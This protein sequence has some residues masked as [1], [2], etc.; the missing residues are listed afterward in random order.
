MRLDEFEYDRKVKTYLEHKQYASPYY[1]PVKAHE[2]YEQHKQLKGNKRSTSTASLNEKGKKAALYVKKQIDEEHKS[3]TEAHNQEISKQ[4]EEAKSNTK[5]KIDA[6]TKE[7]KDKAEAM[8]VRLKKMNPAQRKQAQIHMKAEIEKLKK[9]NEE[10][11]KALMEEYGEV[12]KGISE[13]AKAKRGEINDKY[14]N[15]Y[16]DELDTIKGDASMIKGKKGSSS[17]TKGYTFVFRRGSS[18]SNSKD[19]KKYTFSKNRSK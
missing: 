6:A 9:A 4:R 18:N 19:T 2:Y 11:R 15:K 7:L 13:A 17:K 3:E 8:K 16:A 1:D 5:A 10:N 14:L 12:S